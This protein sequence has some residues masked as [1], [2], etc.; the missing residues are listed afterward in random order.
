MY[1]EF[2]PWNNPPN[3]TIGRLRILDDNGEQVVLAE[4]WDRTDE[5]GL[6]KLLSDLA[7]STAKKKEM[8]NSK[9]VIE[10]DLNLRFASDLQ[11]VSDSAKG[12]AS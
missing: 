7:D 11:K 3:N 4:K 10:A 8:E 2:T 12:G 6:S 1:I 9:A 5:K